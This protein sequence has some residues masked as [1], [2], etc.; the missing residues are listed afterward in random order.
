MK[1]VPRML[2]LATALLAFPAVRGAQATSVNLVSNGGFEQTSNGADKM[3]YL[4]T[5]LTGWSL[6]PINQNNVQ[7]GSAGTYSFVMTS[8]TATVNPPIGGAFSMVA[9]T[10][11]PDGGNL[12]AATSEIGSSGQ[13]QLS[14]TITG[15]TPGNEYTLSF[16]EGLGQRTGY[17][18]A[19]SGFWD[20]T[21]AG[22]TYTSPTVNTPSGGFSGWEL[23]TTTFTAASANEV[24]MFVFNGSPAGSYPVGVLDGIWLGEGSLPPPPAP[25]PEIDPASF[26]SALALVVGALGILERRA[27]KLLVAAVA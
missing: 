24:L 4:S 9:G 5:T 17:T 18:G 16:Y 23:R 13:Q 15:L 21:F 20:V 2:L 7:W 19:T 1:T 10:D 12:F 26:G 6:T 25:V 3:T 27:R 22:Q 11:S 8:P 14:Q